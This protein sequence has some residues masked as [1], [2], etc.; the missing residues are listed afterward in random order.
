MRGDFLFPRKS[1][2]RHR[3]ADGTP[4]TSRDTGQPKSSEAS[5]RH[6]ARG[7]GNSPT[8]P[9]PRSRSSQHGS[10]EHRSGADRESATPTPAQASSQMNQHTFNQ[11]ASVVRQCPWML[12]AEIQPSA[13]DPNAE[14]YPAIP[15]SF[16]HDTPVSFVVTDYDRP[17]HPTFV[18]SCPLEHV[19]LIQKTLAPAGSSKKLV[20]RG[21]SG[22][23]RGGDQLRSMLLDGTPNIQLALQSSSGGSGHPGD[24]TAT[25]PPDGDTDHPG[26][27]SGSRKAGGGPGNAGGVSS[28]PPSC[29]SAGRQPSLNTEDGA[30]APDPTFALPA[31]IPAT[32]VPMLQPG[33][34]GGLGEKTANPQVPYPLPPYMNP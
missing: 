8:A 10:A 4:S 31:F 30:K 21:S 12:G 1:R 29:P 7:S 22:R 28:S 27:S 9:T 19:D 11:L 14:F 15:R 20:A 26:T 34:P 18:I 13:T 33:W 3:A 25:H 16:K 17:E 6:T 32:Y 2:N 24:A 5:S 23:P